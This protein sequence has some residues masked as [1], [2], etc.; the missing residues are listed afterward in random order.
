MMTA[1][2][3]IPLATLVILVFVLRGSADSV[4]VRHTQGSLHGF[5]VLKDTEDKILASGELKQSLAGA[6]VAT[7]MTLRFKDGSFYEETAAYSQKQTFR[8]LNYKQV[9]KGPS[10][11]TPQ[12]MSFDTAT[13]RLSLD[14]MDKGKE[15]I[16]REHLS[17]PSD[18]AN[19]LV[20]LLLANI[21]PGGETTLSMV[22]AAPKPRIVK[23]KI[24]AEGEDSFSV[25]GMGAKATR[26]LIKVDLGP[27]TG[28]L[29]KVVGKQPP[30]IRVWTANGNL[31][32]FLKSEG[33][34]Y[35]DGPVWRIE[36]AAPSW[37]G[38]SPTQ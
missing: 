1:K 14:Y 29:A 9:Q 6:H 17:L 36:L 34:L 20:P 30:P 35:E 22:V 32:V 27:V 25:A 18:L 15:K 3:S 12:T 8:L 38:I 19:G 37:P 11:K 28:T 13:G 5:L 23:L 33:P 24:S 4:P 7:V 21:E 16:D 26:Y 2:S 10:F 31:P